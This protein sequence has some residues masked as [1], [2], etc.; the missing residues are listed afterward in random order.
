MARDHRGSVKVVTSG[1]PALAQFDYLAFG[2]LDESN[3][4]ASGPLAPRI[5][6]RYTGQEFEAKRQDLFLPRPPL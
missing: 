5:R 2:G 1:G 6:R 4:Q 3:S